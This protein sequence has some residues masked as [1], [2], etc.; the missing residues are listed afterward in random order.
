MTAHNYHEPFQLA[1][2]VTVEYGDAGHLLG[3]AWVLVR[4]K[5]DG[6][7]TRLLFSGDLGRKSLPIIRDPEPAPEADY[8]IMESTYGGKLHGPIEAVQDRLADI[9]ARTA[10]RGGRLIIPA[11]AVGRTQQ[12]VLM[13]HELALAK[14]IPDVPI[15]VDSPLAVNATE[16]YRN[17]P[18]CYDPE[19]AAYLNTK[20]GDP[21]GFGLLRYIRELSESKALN[22]MKGPFIVISASG[23]AEAGRILHHLKNNIGNPKNTVLIVGYQ[24]DNTLGK[25][26]VDKLPEVSIFGDMLR[27]R[28]E[29]QVIN[30]LSGHGDQNDL[31]EWMEPT[32]KSLKRVFLV[33]GEPERQEALQS[34]IRAKY[35]DLTVTIPARGESFD[36]AVP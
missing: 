17:H 3:S 23:M 5:K 16:A 8:L 2:G 18:E 12:I 25:K 20:S 11:F 21:F 34:A 1:D 30:E 35:S 9:V 6:K 19:T 10:A 4:H 36:L 27:V 28:A 13:L 24:A 14:R 15:F 31:L 7:E 22:S 32:V 33:H 29:V 26:L